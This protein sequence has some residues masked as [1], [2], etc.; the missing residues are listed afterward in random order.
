MA[1]KRLTQT[2]G[3]RTRSQRRQVISPVSTTN[4]RT[5]RSTKQIQQSPDWRARGER[6]SSILG[7]AK[8]L[9]GFTSSPGESEESREENSRD[10]DSSTTESSGDKSKAHEEFGKDQ[11]EEAGA[12]RE[13]EMNEDEEVEEEGEFEANEEAEEEGEFEADEE[14]EEEGEFGADEESEEEGEFEADEEGE[15]GESE[16]EPMRSDQDRAELERE[17]QSE[18][19][20]DVRQVRELGTFGPYETPEVFSVDGVTQDL[21]GTNP[22]QRRQMINLFRSLQRENQM[23]TQTIRESA[24][25]ETEK[26]PKPAKST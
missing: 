1:T 10:E 22:T 8:K 6:N 12:E 13:P 5:E 19:M 20:F 11:D 15:L 21:T 17:G 18:P 4:P 14:S 9:L 2:A 7:S 3:V 23:L 26:A 24:S 16:G 25:K